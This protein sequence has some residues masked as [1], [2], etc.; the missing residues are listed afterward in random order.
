L[1]VPVDGRDE[2]GEAE[3]ARELSRRFRD[4]RR[5]LELTLDEVAVRSGLSWSS[6][7]AV[8]NGGLES[9]FTE[10]ILVAVALEYDPAELLGGIRWTPGPIAGSGTWHVEPPRGPF[11]L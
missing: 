8:E 1:V 5:V 6:V 7:A 3:A 11:Q 4:R 9:D 10:M 2:P